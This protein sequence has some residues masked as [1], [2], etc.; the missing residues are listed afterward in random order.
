MKRHITSVILL[1]YC[2][3]QVN[4]QML[5]N[6]AVISRLDDEF[7]VLPNGQVSY[8]I[9]LPVITGTGGMTPKL[10]VTYNSSTKYGLLGYGFDLAG[11][12]IISRGTPNLQDDGRTGTASLNDS[13]FLLDGNRLVLS[14]KV[15]ETTRE[16]RTLN[17]TYAKITAYG[18]E[19]NPSRFKVQTKDGLTFEYTSSSLT[20]G[21]NSTAPSMFWLVSRVTDSVGNSFSVSYSSNSANNE[22]YP[23]RIDYTYNSSANLV[24][25]ASVRFTYIEDTNAVTTYVCGKP[26]KYAHLIKTI[27]NYY[28]NTL[29]RRYTMNYYSYL[30]RS[31]LTGISESTADGTAKR[32]TTFTW[33]RP[34]K[35]DISEDDM[36]DETGDNAINKSILITGDY[37]GD[38]RTDVI[39]MPYTSSYNLTSASFSAQTENLDSIP[40]NIQDLSTQERV[41]IVTPDTAKVMDLLSGSNTRQYNVLTSGQTLVRTEIITE[42]DNDVVIQAVSGNFYGNGV[43]DLA[44]LVRK[45]N[46]QYI[47]YVYK[48]T[49][50]STNMTFGNKEVAFLSRKRYSIH[51]VEVNGDGAADLFVK[52]E[53]SKD[54]AFVLSSST[55][56]YA[57]RLYTTVTGTVSEKWDRVEYV[58]FDGDGLTEIMNLTSNGYRLL[59]SDGQ[60]HF[61]EGIL[62]TNLNKMN[63]I[64][65]GDF[66]GDGKTDM[67]VT[68]TSDTPGSQAWTQW[69][70][71]LS[72][73]DGYFEIKHVY[74][75]FDPLE[76]QIF[77]MD[78]NGDGLDDLFAIKK[79][80]NASYIPT[81][82][83]NKASAD[84]EAQSGSQVL[85][86]MD[87]C[88][89][90]VGDFNGDGKAD[91]LCTANWSSTN[92]MGYKMYRMPTEYGNLLESITDGWD[93]TTEITYKYLSD[94]NVH[95]RGTVCRY[96]LTSFSSPWPVVYGVATPNGIGGQNTKTYFYDNALIHRRGRG[97]LGFE[98]LTIRD[99]TTGTKEIVETDIDDNQY[100]TATKHSETY[101]GLRKTAEKDSYQSL[102]TFSHP[103]G[104]CTYSYQT[105][106]TE[107]YTFDYQSETET[108]YT[109]TH[110]SFDDFG[111]VT[112]ISTVNGDGLTT[113]TNST[114]TN[115]E[116]HWYLGRLTESSVSKGNEDG[117][118]YHTS[119]FEYNQD[120]GILSAEYI[121]P[122]KP[123]GAT[124]KT[125]TH[126]QFGNITQ[127]TLQSLSGGEERIQLSTYDEKG[128]FITTTTNTLG[129]TTS[130]TVD[131]ILGVP[132]TST[133]PDGIT[134]TNSYNSFGELLQ[135]STP[136]DTTLYSTGWSRNMTDAPQ[137]ALFYQYTKSTGNP[138]VFEFFDCLG[139]SLRKVTGG[140]YG[141]KIY[142]DTE[143]NEKGQVWRTSEPYFPGDA[144]YWNVN[145][146]DDMGRIICQTSP[147][148]NSYTMSYNGLTTTTTDPLGHSTIKKTNQSGHLINS[149][150]ADGNTIIYTYDADGNCTTVC[151]PQT[152]LTMAYDVFGNKTSQTDADTGTTTYTYDAF[153]QLTSSTL[154]GNVVVEYEYDCGGRVTKE[155][156]PD[157]TITTTY[158]TKVPGKVTKVE[159]TNGHKIEYTYD[160]YGRQVVRKETIDGNTYT[161][162]TPYNA[163]GKVSTVAYPNGLAV[164]NIY[165]ENGILTGVKWL[166]PGTM[167]WQIDSLTA[168]GQ[169]KQQHLGNGLYINKVYN[170]QKGYV[171]SI[172]TPGKLSWAYGFNAVGNLTS[173]TDILRDLTESFAYDTLD[174]LT[175]V[176]KNGMTTQEMTY[177]A[178]GN[179][180]S[181][182]D[183]GGSFT[184]ASSGNRLQSF[185][186]S[187]Y[188]PVEWD[189]ISYNS[190]NKI[191]HI[192]K[193]GRA[194][195]ITYGAHGQRIKAVQ[196]V[197]G[198]AETRL[199]V[200]NLFEEKQK[201]GITTKIFYIFAGG[202]T[203]AVMERTGSSS[204]I[205]YLHHDHLG[206]V[207]AISDASGN[208]VQELSYDAWGRRRNPDTWNYYD[209]IADADA[210]N[211]YGF[212]GHEHI[213]LF[214]LVNMDGRMY[215][216]VIGRFL[217]PDPI[218]QAP[219]FTQSLN[220]YA[221]CL[222][223]PLSLIDPTGYSWFSK[224]WKSITAS[225]VGIAV[226]VVTAG[227]GSGLGIA[228]IAGAAGGAAGALTGALLNGANIGQIAKSTFTGALVG[229]ASGFLNFA[230]GDGTIWEQ[231]FKHTFSQGWLEGVQG[232]NVFH[233]FMMGSMSSINAFVLKKTEMG[234]VGKIVGN[235]VLSGT[236]D[237][238]GG[239][240]FANGAITGAFNYIFNEAMHGG[241]TQKQLEKIHDIYTQSLKKYKTPQDFYRSIG[242]PEYNYACAARLSYALNLAGIEIPFISGQTRK[243][244]DGRNY[245]MFAEDMGNWFRQVWGQ[246]RTYTNPNKY[247]PKNGVVYQS[248]FSGGVT[249][250]V[251]YFYLG[252]DGHY[253][254]LNGAGARD[255]Y[256][257]GIKTEL[258]KRGR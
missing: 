213:D 71:E 56:L 63:F 38:G 77:V 140:L 197:G 93:N 111:N 236:I 250:H 2:I 1:L 222:N 152:T 47:T 244:N 185:S 122:Y 234:Y 46:G 143:Y 108:S 192:A 80:T 116:D 242:L 214:E 190:Y 225:I 30:G 166:G 180:L 230:S 158:D 200:D 7:A 159:A 45:S 145:E 68:G 126:D 206:S 35:F 106:Q 258:W 215:D 27:D 147:D 62:K 208:I 178:A 226:S 89:Y 176:K 102:K 233:G 150:D 198:V 175:T 25:Y 85:P 29:A 255:Y 249:G 79:T 76:M 84:F 8:S 128:R 19:C 113:I 172:T 34:Y 136:I 146:Y 60:G 139:R 134:T 115:D 153:G 235:A 103:S 216:P 37:N 238:I 104:N 32:P 160:N 28:G 72:K 125:Y 53:N 194:L 168:R 229:G 15:N 123:Y 170:A 130:Y 86:P 231:L 67:L 44:V 51:T 188:Q 144:V 120:T 193:G 10:S 138:Y 52:Y 39:T 199:Y 33:N 227:S 90:Y 107:E 232:G 110:T 204:T 69:N 240:K 75:K 254:G 252:L 218:I 135:S 58:D 129:F 61:T 82:Y 184:Y 248:G 154:P 16:Y 87:K 57:L 257:Q 9:P 187:S 165:S 49:P 195:D 174:R 186:A 92:W 91:F 191:T 157:I 253:K 224:N 55:S 164:E 73:G 133:E 137:H 98:R 220:R 127:S 131:E 26:V 228:I 99:N 12:S 100:L 163:M 109:K 211:P 101:L 217:S 155:T 245:F 17:E 207:I 156:R 223:N 118:V 151:A 41:H 43:D 21:T 256:N 205:R 6:N 141:Q 31:L 83:I 239:G 4:G 162:A 66:N 142:I 241:P 221:Y 149:T 119:K 3:I 196:S 81:A 169:V 243:G 97:V 23:T 11:L 182:S 183:V 54:Y 117:Q 247:T 36:Q 173:R 24:P 148:G 112:Y 114:Y 177:D 209:E 219:D 161:V 121:E 94:R 95:Y 18:S 124:K 14:N 179:I 237:E 88:N 202:Q 48:S 74:R 167:L 189:D 181:K 22:F 65:F 132:L 212:T 78:I 203:V 251:E 201:S 13:I 64:N 246:P 40:T 96:P 20:V 171:E 105:L 5:P 210:L 70:I 50:T 42:N 59:T